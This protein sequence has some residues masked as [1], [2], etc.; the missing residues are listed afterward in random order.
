MRVDKCRATH[1]Q[2]DG[3]GM[4]AATAAVIVIVVPIIICAAILKSTNMIRIVVSRVQ[5]ELF[6][7]SKRERTGF[8]SKFS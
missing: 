8:V 5:V 4:L 2:N 1:F 7:N 6:M 3:H